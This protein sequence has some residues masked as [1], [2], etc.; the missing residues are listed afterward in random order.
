LKLAFFSAWYADGRKN[1]QWILEYFAARPVQF[2]NA[3]VFCFLGA[4]WEAFSKRLANLDLNFE[5]CRYARG[6]AGEYARYKAQLAGMDALIYTGFD[7]GAMSVY[8]AIA[9]GVSVIATNISYHRGLGERVR[10]FEDREGF[11]AELDRLYAQYAERRDLL[12]TRSV[13]SYAQRLVAHWS[14]LAGPRLP[15]G[16]GVLD[17]GTLSK[18]EVLGEFRGRYKRLD[19]SRLRSAAIRLIQYWA[20]K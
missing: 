11:F 12:Q 5:V 9:E 6:L 3:F 19:G 17:S 20:N 15:P 4:E 7:G 18:I 2:R 10:L 8:D 1:E 16:K 14:Q 13:S